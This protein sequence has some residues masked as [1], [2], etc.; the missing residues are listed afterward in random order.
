M[1][2]ECGLHTI[3]P[4]TRMAFDENIGDKEIGQ[5]ARAGAV[6][7][8]V[9]PAGTDDETWLQDAWA[10]GADVVVSNDSDIGNIIQKENYDM[11]WKL[12]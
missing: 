5:Y 11:T 12:P 3:E 4:G 10:A 2:R 6:I 8:Y 1:S 7:V 9:S